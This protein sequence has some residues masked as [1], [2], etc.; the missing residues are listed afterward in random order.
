MT[1]ML[2]RS[3]PHYSRFT[4]LL[5]EISFN[6]YINSKQAALAY[7][8]A[9]TPETYKHRNELYNV[10]ERCIIPE[11]LNAAFQTKPTKKLTLLAFNLFTG[12]T[13]FS[14]D[15]TP[16]NIFD[17][18]LSECFIEAVRIRHSHIFGDYEKLKIKTFLEK[19]AEVNVR[20]GSEWLEPKKEDFEYITEIL[21]NN[22]NYYHTRTEK[23][24]AAQNLAEESYM[25]ASESDKST[26]RLDLKL[27]E[28]TAEI[29]GLKLK[30]ARTSLEEYNPEAAASWKPTAPGTEC[31]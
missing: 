4:E 13:A 9:A 23:F 22:V 15:C 3:N 25:N 2:F 29:E 12:S 6:G 18:K 16:D 26:A 20:F 11:G 21:L 7:L 1:T 24:K 30:I 28:L 14:G 5:K 19:L 8:L 31:G 10:Q 17:C 27:A